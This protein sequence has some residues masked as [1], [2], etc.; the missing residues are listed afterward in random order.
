MENQI[1]IHRN[2]VQKHSKCLNWNCSKMLTIVVSTA[3]ENS[4][5]CQNQLLI[6]RTDKHNLVIKF[7][8]VGLYYKVDQKLIIWIGYWKQQVNKMS[9]YTKDDWLIEFISFVKNGTCTAKYYI[10]KIQTTDTHT[11]ILIL[12]F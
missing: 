9:C 6:I 4:P 1:P 2:T 3:T 11:C 8:I 7:L 10:T 5:L 12:I